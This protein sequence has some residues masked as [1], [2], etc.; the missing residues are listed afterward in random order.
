[1]CNAAGKYS[2]SKCWEPKLGGSSHEQITIDRRPSRDSQVSTTFL[3]M[4]YPIIVTR[5]TNDV[6]QMIVEHH[7]SIDFTALLAIHSPPFSLLYNSIKLLCLLKALTSFFEEEKKTICLGNC[8]WVQNQ[9]LT[10]TTSLRYN[11]N[12]IHVILNFIISRTELNT[13]C[14]FFVSFD[15][16]HHHVE[17]QGHSHTDDHHQGDK[18]YHHGHRNYH[19][20]DGNYHH[21]HH[22][23]VRRVC[24]LRLKAHPPFQALWFPC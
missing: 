5:T 7:H 24:W 18:N 9:A 8:T 20:I 12:R 4:L 16:H 17:D 3:I 6:W 22:D 21:G 10:N 2:W 23:D 19:H 13:N 1:M 11:F 14:F 15:Q